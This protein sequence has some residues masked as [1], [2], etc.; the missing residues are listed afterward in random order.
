M[1]THSHAQAHVLIPIPAAM[2][3]KCSSR[4][5]FPQCLHLFLAHSFWRLR[6]GMARR[7]PRLEECFLANSYSPFRDQIQWHYLQEAFSKSHGPDSSPGAGV[8]NL[9]PHN[10]H[11]AVINTLIGC[12]R[13]AASLRSKG[14]FVLGTTL[15]VPST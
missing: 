11:V 2:A 10:S 1:D 9:P 7:Y 12:L 8:L 14:A 5:P 3:G 15:S 6:H 13:A 4:P